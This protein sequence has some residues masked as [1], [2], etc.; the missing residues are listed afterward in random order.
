MK[1]VQEVLSEVLRE[2][3]SD[4][5]AEEAIQEGIQEVSVELKAN[6][7]NPTVLILCEDGIPSG[8]SLNDGKKINFL[9]V[10][11]DKVDGG[12]EIEIQV[13]PNVTEADELGELQGD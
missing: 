13:F 8:Y 10:N 3:I 1:T 4:V 7:E 5:D 2:R 12:G 9:F 6:S 11:L